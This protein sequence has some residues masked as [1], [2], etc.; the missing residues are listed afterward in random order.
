LSVHGL[1]HAIDFGTSNSAV[2]VGYGDGTLTQ[3]RDPASP[4]ESSS[5]RTSV[6]VLRDGQV[7]VGHAAENA[8][9]LR[10]GAYRGEFKREF[11]DRTPTTLAGR[12]MTPDE[13]TV[14]VL[15]FLREQAQGAVPGEPERVVIT[16]PASW[17]A[18][19]RDLMRTVAG[20]AGY[21]PAAVRLI[22]E[23]VAALAYAF[24]EH[25]D[26]AD[27]M[28]AL[29]Y[30]LGGGTFDCA[31]AR[32]TA[33]GHEILGEPGGLD[34][35]G[36]AAFD[37]LLLGLIRDRFGEPAAALL[38][39]A[40]GDPDVLRRRLMLKDRCE[41]IKCQLSVT[42]NHEDLLSELVPPGVL[43]LARAELEAL[44]RPLLAE[45]LAECDDLLA[46]LGLGWADVD[47][48]VPVGGS[49]RIPLVG[50]LLAERT[51]RPVLRVD[52][53]EMAIVHGGALIARAD[54]RDQERA[55]A[56]SNA[57]QP[58]PGHLGDSQPDTNHANGIDLLGELGKLI[59]AGRPWGGNR[60]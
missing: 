15:R 58:G 60:T 31:V 44:I 50:Q 22:A 48:V 47:R 33:Q 7:A 52:H 41:A 57:G 36:G 43:D 5:I 12:P 3:V 46:R 10:A 24:A 38:D 6:C 56:Q 35:V 21:D 49:S 11:G 54:A 37:R 17:E 4:A 40:A 42:G 28:T 55:A 45:T 39:S 8:K 9:R 29:V 19:N 30:D 32:G 26:P 59:D 2:I 27:R 34:D 18:G 23:P 13:M 16:V 14:E 51:R 53:P 20:L 25:H 1:L